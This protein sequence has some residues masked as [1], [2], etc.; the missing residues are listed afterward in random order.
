VRHDKTIFYRETLL[1]FTKFKEYYG[2]FMTMFKLRMLLIREVG[3]V[4]IV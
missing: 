2:R 1:I 4:K 3:Q